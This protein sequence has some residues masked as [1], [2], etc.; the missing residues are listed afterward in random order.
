MTGE[1]VQ[2]VKIL[3]VMPDK[4]GSILPHVREGETS[5]LFSGAH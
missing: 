1:M 4:L 3:K 2:G 5:S